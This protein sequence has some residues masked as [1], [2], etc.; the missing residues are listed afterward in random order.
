M[1]EGVVSD[2]QDMNGWDEFSAY[3][4][5]NSAAGKKS[6]NWPLDQR[7]PLERVRLWMQASNPGPRFTRSPDTDEASVKVNSAEDIRNIQNAPDEWGTD[8]I[9]GYRP[10][11]IALALTDL[12][13]ILAKKKS[14]Y[15][16]GDDFWNFEF[17]ADTM[18][19]DAS[20]SDVMR[21]LIGIKL[22]RIQ[23]LLAEGSDPEN[24]SLLDSFRDLAGYAIILYAYW[25]EMLDGS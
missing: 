23:N 16:T 12:D 11:P 3:T 24:E 17:A 6:I 2:I 13:A 10:G 5:L 25:K 15:S 1:G 20:P 14:D 19:G 18:G 21:A 9:E 4:Y 22:G 7:V 8:D